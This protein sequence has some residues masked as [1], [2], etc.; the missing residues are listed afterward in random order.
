MTSVLV[1]T[2]DPHLLHELT[3]L[4][5]AAGAGLV[6]ASDT[7]DVLRAW[8]APLVLVG[9]DV[10]DRLAGVA[11]PRHDHVYVVG[12]DPLPDATYRAA[13][14]LGAAQVVGLPTGSAWLSGLMADLGDDRAR[15]G[16]LVGVV[17]GSGGAGAT[18]L[19]CA[20]AQVAS[21]DGPSVVVDV[22]PL[23][24]GA[25]RVL[26]LDDTTGVRWDDLVTTSGRL[27][28]R[29]F[30]DA[31]PTRDGLGVLTWS[32]GSTTT[33]P[34]SAVRES[35]SAARRGHD[36]VVVDLPRTS[37]PGLDET[38]VRCDL[39]VLV[40][41]ASVASLAAT[42]RRVARLPD[43]GRARIVARGRG[44]DPDDLVALTGLPVIA[45]MRDQR[46]LG[47]SVDLGLGPVRGRRGPLARAARRVLA[48]L[49]T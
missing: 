45:A 29:A 8:S 18:T 23:G 44:L 36:V 37:G 46:G 21:R 5:A 28:A 48:E 1:A 2:R 35:L 43:H 9:T 4:V 31:L 11:P 13:L 25:D 17:G 38:L 19:A 27:G 47:E 39:V 42:T 41:R 30:R 24:P 7:A 26:G 3:R 22:D 33:L 10:A 14:A 34:D 15:P 49:A 12:P 20:V 32:A 16:L 40:V 6:E